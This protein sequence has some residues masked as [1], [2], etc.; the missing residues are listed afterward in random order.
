MC[1]QFEGVGALGVKGWGLLCV[2]AHAKDKEKFVQ[3]AVRQT[4][5]ASMWKL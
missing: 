3:S 2:A 5:S 4:R 1:G